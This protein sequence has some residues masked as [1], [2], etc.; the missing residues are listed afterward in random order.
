M[1]HLTELMQQATD[2]L[3]NADRPEHVIARVQNQRRRTQVICATAGTVLIAAAIA[4]PLI[5]GGND[6]ADTQRIISVATAPPSQALPTPTPSPT[7]LPGGDMIAPLSTPTKTEGI[8]TATVQLGDRPAAANE[9]QATL[10]CLSS[11]ALSFPGG[12]GMTCEPSDLQR[13]DARRTA[14]Y[15]IALQ[16]GQRTLTLTAPGGTRWRLTS[17]YTRAV[18]K[19]WGVNPSGQTYGTA[20]AKGIPDLVAVLATNG[21][22]GYA[23]A[24]QLW[25]TMPTSPAQASEQQKQRQLDP[26]PRAVPVYESDGK[27]RIGEFAMG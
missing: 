5:M 8:G 23:Y 17:V 13:S 16:P 6:H 19:P 18:T 14:T 24:S 10:T 3:H 9:V 20:N 12:A 25:G 7:V 11:G 4:T 15:Q 21:R 1:N 2:D 26:S 27:T 22:S